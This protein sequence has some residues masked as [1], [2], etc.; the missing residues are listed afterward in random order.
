MDEITKLDAARRQLLAAIHIHWYCN[1][2]IAV[3]SLA[4]NVWEICDTLSK[5]AN[6]PTIADHIGEAH[7]MSF[8]D[9]KKL[10]NAPRNFIKH[11]DH[12][13]DGK[14]A[15]IS[16]LDCD[17]VVMTACLDYMA[18]SKRSPTIFGLFV[19]WYC[20]I[21]PDK[22]GGFFSD[23]AALY[24]PHLQAMERRDQVKAARHQV[25]QPLLSEVLN[26]ARNEM[27]DN[28]RWINL[29]EGR[30]YPW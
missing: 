16:H 30:P 4:S 25:A 28:W 9:V 10:I 27:T 22:V 8:V 23:A 17:A 18:A 29:R 3:Y 12:D 5:R 7:G 1:E 19:F 26:D 6:R 21:Y 14:I 15:D 20:S 24:F 11:A 13:P 2:P